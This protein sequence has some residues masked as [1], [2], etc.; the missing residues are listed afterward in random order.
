MK[1]RNNGIYNK[2]YNSEEDHENYSENRELINK[3]SKNIINNINIFMIKSLKKSK[4]P[5]KKAKVE[6]TDFFFLYLKNKYNLDYKYK[7]C[8]DFISD[9]N[10]I[11]QRLIETSTET[12]AIYYI[13]TNTFNLK[14]NK[15]R[16]IYYLDKESVKKKKLINP[17]LSIQF[18]R[19]NEQNMSQ[20]KTDFLKQYTKQRKLIK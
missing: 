20:K 15:K 5:I 10:I 18:I 8:E 1:T 7:I 14:L 17:T 19:E 9:F 6:L 3:I 11:N 12:K 4:N 2:G 16:F 13:K